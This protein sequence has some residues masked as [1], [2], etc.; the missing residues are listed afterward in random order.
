MLAALLTIGAGTVAPP[1]AVA[2]CTE[3]YEA[4]QI[5]GWQKPNWLIRELKFVECFADFVGCL[6]SA[7]GF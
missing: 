6:K 4:C 2:G 7:A 5:T 3:K 1:P